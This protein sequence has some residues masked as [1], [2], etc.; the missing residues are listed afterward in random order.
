MEASF[1]DS[2]KRY[3]GF[4]EESAAA[5][6]ELYPLAAPHFTRIVDDF[7]AA[8]EAH[9]GARAAITGGEAQI[10]RL[11][12]TLIRWL[13]TMLT[14]PHD[15][16][17][18][19]MRARIGRVHVRINLPQSYMFTAM[20]RIRIHLLNVL[21]ERLIDRAQDFKRLSTALHQIIDL[22]LAIMLETYR[23]DLAAKNRTAER[24]ATIGEF[25][26][27]LGHELRNPLGVIESSVYLL[28]QYLGPAAITNLNVAK[29]LD[30][31]AG[32]ATRSN[33]T[34][35]DLLDLA[36]SRR[37]RRTPV[38]LRPIVQS[39]LDVAALPEGVQVSAAIPADLA[40]SM[41]PDQ[42]RQVLCNL[43]SN[44]REAMNGVGNVRI[45]SEAVA[46][47][48][49][50]R[51]SDDGP[52]VQTDIRLRIFEALFTTKARGNGLGLGL[53]RRIMA[54]H[55]G[56]IELESTEG[57]ATFILWIPTVFEE[58]GTAVARPVA[59]A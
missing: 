46:D 22:E 14:G 57:P 48:V 2:L 26:A 52:G 5:L 47:G 19:E 4:T 44:A 49:R 42:L 33:K 51:V 37:P 56:T 15:E 7:Y 38:L 32:E 27:S 53:C 18:F 34:I 23:E 16:A 28:R 40:V 43:F 36:Q 29:H 55:G 25:A 8:I 50:L 45:E 54:A 58:A 41:D 20:N 24:L 17:Y 11:K 12:Q 3:V 6:R 1:F 13:E 39:A 30:R 31:I 10:G 59:H 35:Q 21:H 9:P